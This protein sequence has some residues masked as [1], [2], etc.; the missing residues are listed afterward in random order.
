MSQEDNAV[1]APASPILIRHPTPPVLP[2][3][4]TDNQ[5]TPTR[6]PT[7]P[8]RQIFA[9]DDDDDELEIAPPTKRA[10]PNWSKVSFVTST[11]SIDQIGF[12]SFNSNANEERKRD[13]ELLQHQEP[14]QPAEPF[15]VNPA[16]A[17]TT[18]AAIPSIA[19]LEAAYEE[20][21]AAAYSPQPTKSSSLSFSSIGKRT[22]S[23]ASVEVLKSKFMENNTLPTL[24][25][26]YL[27]Q[28]ATLTAKELLDCFA[29][30]RQKATE[31]SLAFIFQPIPFA[32]T[33]T[34]V[35]SDQI[36]IE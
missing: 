20:Y 34:T 18:P 28:K 33:T 36:R 6:Q 23:R 4:K 5:P 32:T 11:T 16:T 29:Q 7:S 12:I 35:Q 21:L 19:A 30:A 13:L 2:P 3:R 9:V 25:G 27:N 24:L 17:V 22:G 31:K 14:Q 10:K 15:A 26:Q 8:S 1:P